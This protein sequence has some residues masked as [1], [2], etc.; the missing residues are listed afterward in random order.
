MKI[1]L[2]Q[3]PVED[4]YATPMRTYPLGL[5]CVASG[6]L[7]CGHD[8]V[9]YDAMAA[10][11][12]SVLAVPPRFEHLAEYYRPGDK[13]PYRLFGHYYHFGHSWEEIRARIRQEKPDLIGIS[14]LF[15]PYH[16]MALRVA[17][18][19]RE[20]FPAVPVVM[21]GA[22]VTACGE[23]TG[24][25]DHV[26][27]GEGECAFTELTGGRVPDNPFR[28]AHGLLDPG[29]YRYQGKRMAFVLTSRG[30][31]H[32]CTFCSVHASTPKFRLIQ[33]AEVLTEIQELVLDYGVRHIDIEDDCFGYDAGHAGEILRG[34][35]SLGVPGLSLSFMNG[36][37]AD[38][39]TPEK[40]SLLKQAGFSTLNLSLV[41]S[42]PALNRRYCRPFNAERFGQTVRDAAALGF[43]ITAYAILGLPGDTVEGMLNTLDTL[44]CLPVRIGASLFYPVPGTRVFR[45]CVDKGFIQPE[46]YDVF[47][48]TAACVETPEFSRR[49]L[50]TLFYLCRI[51]NLEKERAAGNSDAGPRQALQEFFGERKIF[52]YF[53]TGREAAPVSEK[54][55]EGFFHRYHNQPSSALSAVL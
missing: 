17:K 44:R 16:S 53:K 38:V 33:P 9:L 45:D 34:I 49:D 24:V 10:G 12:K 35:F 31:P 4:F 48:L 15:T 25:A 37:C 3:P 54:V 39:L 52:R 1:L 43:A 6:P 27:K 22:H 13:S 40:L 29:L 8:V 19:A 41:S 26:I 42:N 28:P 5:A 46:D 50:M 7:A 2:I 55:L 20:C 21:G 36:L 47:R 23:P 30:C 11:R 18:I 51:L 32:T 14:S